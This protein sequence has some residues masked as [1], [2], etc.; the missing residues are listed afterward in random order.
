MEAGGHILVNTYAGHE[1]FWSEVDKAH[2][3]PTGRLEVE[4]G[5][6]E[7]SYIVDSDKEKAHRWKKMAEERF[8]KEEDLAKGVKDEL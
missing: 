3:L 4:L 7:Y 6:Y 5:K 1:F 2:P 8:K